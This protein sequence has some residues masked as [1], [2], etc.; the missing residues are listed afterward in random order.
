MASAKILIVDDSASSRAEL[1]TILEAAEAA[2]E[3]NQA[4]NGAVGLKLAAE[5]GPDIIISDLEM[6]VLDGRA[7]CRMLRA[8]ARMRAIPFVM[9]ASRKEQ[10]AR[11][12]LIDA[13]VDDYLTRPLDA[14][15]LRARVG[16]LLRLRQAN[17]EL[18]RQ[19]WE[20]QDSRE[21]ELAARKSA[22]AGR[23]AI[24]LSH[25]FNNAIGSMISNVAFLRRELADVV[26]TV[27]PSDPAAWDLFVEDA[28]EVVASCERLLARMMNT[29]EDVQA[30]IGADERPSQLQVLAIGDIVGEA[31]RSLAT[32]HAAAGQLA[33]DG[34]AGATVMAERTGVSSALVLLLKFVARRTD[35]AQLSITATR[36]RS[37]VVLRI[38]APAMQL[39]PGEEARF[40][41]PRLV[42]G[43]EQRMQLSVDLSVC[44]SYIARS[45]GTVRVAAADPGTELEVRLTAAP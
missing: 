43:E 4:E 39:E 28:G 6:P 45:E 21:R 7:F 25:E 24:G 13:G 26:P 37:Q 19:F 42:V 1:C 2:Y 15:E 17:L 33:L 18:E 8:N 20:L 3:I 11:V 41:D 10:G 14:A 22:F 34:D 31:L 29:V 36:E 5:I 30:L 40:F 16:S 32:T 44:V 23:L 12:D 9:V 38:A 35:L 27:T